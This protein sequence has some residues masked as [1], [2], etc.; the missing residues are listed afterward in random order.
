RKIHPL[1]GVQFPVIINRTMA[2]TFWPGDE[3][4]GQVFELGGIVQ[5]RVIGIVGDVNEWGIR[6]RVIPE[7]YWTLSGAFDEFGRP[8][9]ITLKSQGDPNVLAILLRA[10]VH[11]LDN[12]LALFRVRTMEEVIS[13][14]TGGAHYRMVL[15][16]FFALLALT[17]A[18][19][20]IYGVMAYTVNQRTHEIGVRLALG[21][22]KADVVRM[23]AS[24]G[25]RLTL[26]GLAAG[27]AGSLALTR[28]LSS[29]L[30]GVTPTDPLTF[31]A[32][33]LIL[34]G[35][36]LLACYIPARRAAKVDP[37]VAL[38]YE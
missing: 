10:Q 38:R 27:L 14:A 21:A 20:G 4:L 7:A 33:S 13:E 28:L 24:Q 23:V 19:I 1:P 5:A 32:V 22:Q 25:L 36:A 15:F 16:G 2:K 29:L 11:A 35:V 8:M 34:L 26:A 12:S 6:E 17:L 31:G 18:A 3:A 30:Y 37:M 9:I